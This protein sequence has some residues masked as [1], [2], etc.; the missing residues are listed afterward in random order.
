MLSHAKEHDLATKLG[1]KWELA[2]NEIEEN[3][4]GLAKYVVEGIIEIIH[5]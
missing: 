4:D 3:L 5:P 1:K 2:H